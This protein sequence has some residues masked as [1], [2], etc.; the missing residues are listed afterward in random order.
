MSDDERERCPLCGEPAAD[1]S[2]ATAPGQCV[3][4][5]DCPVN[6]WDATKVDD[7]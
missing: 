2:W 1:V 7:Q 6:T 3:C 5:G 4:T